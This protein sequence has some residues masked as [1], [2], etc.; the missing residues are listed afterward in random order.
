[1][2]WG[3]AMK[4]N[5]GVAF[6]LSVFL[7]VV[8]IMLW[9]LI[10]VEGRQARLNE[11]LLDAVNRENAPVAIGLLRSGADPN[12]C[13]DL[14]GPVYQC[15]RAL[16]FRA[17]RPIA[18]DPP[19]LISLSCRRT[20]RAARVPIEQPELV[21]ELLSRGA[22]ATVVDRYGY[23]PLR[24]AIESGKTGTVRLLLRHGADPKTDDAGNV[25]CDAII[26]R[27]D[28]AIVEMLFRYGADPNRA[29]DDSTPL[30]WAL[31][32]SDCPNVS[33]LL[34]HKADP[35]KTTY[36]GQDF[37]YLRPLEYAVRVHLKSS[38]EMLSKAGAAR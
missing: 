2:G 36:F 8:L 32:K 25:L 23:S 33:I 10:A 16:F 28:P 26:S 21:E 1:M 17:A 38:A 27:A 34:A 7:S 37:G 29:C 9:R 5:T 13:A 35:N 18:G 19:L 14:E 6:R 3:P 20:A 30:G 31:R 4:R 15:F 12:C 11:E 24:Y 22:R